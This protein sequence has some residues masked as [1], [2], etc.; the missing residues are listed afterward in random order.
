[1]KYV[2]TWSASTANYTAAISRFLETGGLPPAGVKMLARYHALEGSNHG[3]IVAE[4]PD[5]KGI[6][7]WLA[8]W[9]DVV[10]FEATPVLEDAEAA[11]ILQSLRK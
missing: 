2:T 3:F 4:S 7:T 11:G 10:S 8:G 9:M 5:A 1:M 6:F